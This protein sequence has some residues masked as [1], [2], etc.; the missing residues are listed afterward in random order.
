MELLTVTAGVESREH[1]EHKADG[2]RQKTTFFREDL[3]TCSALTAE[4][5]Q[6]LNM[7]CTASA[8]HIVSF[9]IR[10]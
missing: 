10:I 2:K 7:A 9:G 5:I 1:F 4:H 6:E 3:T 8:Y